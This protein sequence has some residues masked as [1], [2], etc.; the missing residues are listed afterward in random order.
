MKKLIIAVIS[1]GLAG[2]S[3]SAVPVDQAMNAPP[4]RVLKYQNN[5]DGDAELT[6]VRDSGITGGACYASVF[7]NGEK[8]AILNT[9]EKASLY[10]PAGDYIVGAAFSGSGLC[11]MGKERQE[12]SIKVVSGKNQVIRVYSDSNA[13]M[14]IKPTTL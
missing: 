6:I 1:L 13:N 10:L 9:S 2:C 3:T 11:S 4:E 14:D 12:R 5:K 7:I 8:A